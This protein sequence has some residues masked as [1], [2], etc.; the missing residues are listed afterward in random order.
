MRWIVAALVFPG[1]LVSGAVSYLDTELNMFFPYI[2]NSIFITDAH[3]TSSG[4]VASCVLTIDSNQCRGTN[5]YFLGLRSFWP[6]NRLL[7][8]R[9]TRAK[10][11]K[12][13]WL[14]G[15]VVM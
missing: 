7:G 2:M 12:G 6:G 3:S 4:Y 10:Q 1:S 14:A 9:K 13:R 11:Q 15:H 5:G 8:Y